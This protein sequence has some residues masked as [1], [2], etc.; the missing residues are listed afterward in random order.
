MPQTAH[1]LI[2]PGRSLWG[3]AVAVAGSIALNLTLF[4][5]MPGLIQRVPNTP[6]KLDELSHIQVVRVKRPETP[7]QKKE[8]KKNVPPEPVKQVKHTPVN[9]MVQKTIAKPYLKFELNP[10]LP[11]APT[12]LVMPPLENF[13]LDAPVL[14]A[15][16]DIAELDTGL[17]ALVKIPPIYPIQAK[18]RGIEGF[19]DVEFIVTAAGIVQDIKITAARPKTIF[20]SAVI[21]CVSRWKFKPPTVEGIP[22][23]TRAATTIKF[24][25]EGND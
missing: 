3:W 12:D 7:L 10:K 19:V 6:D 13:S 21:A 24:K 15:V 22:V 2:R 16:Y 17:M 25:L 23:A 9:P 8:P 1:T 18:R 20:N 5:L 11:T 14:K 4:G